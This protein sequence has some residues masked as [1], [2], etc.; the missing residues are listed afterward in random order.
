MAPSLMATQP[1]A[2]EAEPVRDVAA[3]GAGQQRRLLDVLHRCERGRVQQ[4]A[5]EQGPAET[6]KVVRGRDDGAGTPRPHRDG[7]VPGHR[8]GLIVP[9]DASHLTRVGGL[10]DEH[11]VFQLERVEHLAGEKLGEGDTGGIFE[12]EARADEAEIGVL[13]AM[14]RFARPVTR[15]GGFEAGRRPR[16]IRGP[17][18]VGQSGGVREQ[19]AQGCV[20]GQTGEAHRSV[21]VD[22]SALS[23]THRHGRREDLGHAGNRERSRLVDIG[24]RRGRPHH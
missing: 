8:T 6:S 13:E 20:V 10:F 4:V 23:Q 2:M 3:V 18:F 12:D 11:R 15:G 7:G 22:V 19:I 16:G 9:I 1:A 21:E 5:V 24:V 14:P 17:G